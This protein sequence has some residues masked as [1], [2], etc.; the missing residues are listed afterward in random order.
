MINT[1]KLRTALNEFEASGAHVHGRGEPQP[2]LACAIRQLLG[3]PFVPEEAQ[4]EP[5]T[6][7][8]VS[9]T[10]EITAAMDFTPGML[11]RPI[12]IPKRSSRIMA[13]AADEA[14][15]RRCSE[16]GKPWGLVFVKIEEEICASC[17]R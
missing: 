11:R 16:C 8:D 5:C 10:E 6:V 12:A 9:A 1:D 17:Q 14:R 7:L 3:L 4:S 15:S 2:C 13:E